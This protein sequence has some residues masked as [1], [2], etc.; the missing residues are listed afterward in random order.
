MD[1]WELNKRGEKKRQTRVINVYDQNIQDEQGQRTRPICQVQWESIL[2]GRAIL[3]GDFNA[4]SP[5]WDPYNKPRNARDLEGLI[6]R[7]DLILNNDTIVFTRVEGGKRSVLDLTFSS[8]ELGPLDS[9]AIAEGIQTP[10]DHK[11]IVLEITLAA[12]EKGPHIVGWRTDKLSQ[13]QK[14]KME[15]EWWSRA[16]QFPQQQLLSNSDI[17]QEALWIQET[18]TEILDEYTQPI[19][20]TPRSKRWWNK[21]VKESRKAFLRERRLHQ[22]GWATWEELKAI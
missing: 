10:S 2:Q 1:V 21:T 12:E 13:E 9:W 5:H 18:V 20:I 4:K 6:E 22:R 17:E 8:P 15:A 7:F 11:P 19:K 16:I 3:L 14:E